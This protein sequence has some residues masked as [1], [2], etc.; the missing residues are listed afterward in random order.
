MSSVLGRLLVE[1]ML[2]RVKLRGGVIERRKGGAEAAK[3]LF[4]SLPSD[5]QLAQRGVALE[6]RKACGT[7]QG[8]AAGW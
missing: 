2:S 5:A 4:L 7:N 8:D 6:G 3:T 1:M